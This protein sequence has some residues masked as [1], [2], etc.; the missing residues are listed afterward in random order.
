[1]LLKSHEKTNFLRSL[2]VVKH[3]LRADDCTPVPILF[4]QATFRGS[5]SKSVRLQGPS[6][7]LGAAPVA[8]LHIVL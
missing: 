3:R 8:L 4:S 5:A 7:P 1:M 6:A 2:M